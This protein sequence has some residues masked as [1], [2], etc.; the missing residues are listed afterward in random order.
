MMIFD[1]R[2]CLE[3]IDMQ[4]D[5]YEG[6][7]M[8]D[9][10]GTES[11]GY[12]NANGAQSNAATTSP[13]LPTMSVSSQKGGKDENLKDSTCRECGDDNISMQY[14]ETFGIQV[15]KGCC[16]ADKKYKLITKTTAKE[17]LLVT[18]EDLKPLSFISRKNP[19][20]DGWGDMKL[21][22][23]VQVE[24]IA[25]ERYGDLVGVE[26][27]KLKRQDDKYE[28][29]KVKERNSHQVIVNKFH[30]NALKFSS[31]YM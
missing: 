16:A 26:A 11:H 4:D 19:R 8:P 21:F 12:N 28:R 10:E 14:R 9:G 27:A 29:L 5:E 3:K 22:L 23:R 17:E 25:F 1:T 24:D 15:C 30:S 20:K 18:D 6:G 31:I 7:F 2:V 13:L